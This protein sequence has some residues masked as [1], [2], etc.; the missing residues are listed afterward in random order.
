LEEPATAKDID[1]VA[2]ETGAAGE[3]VCHC[4]SCSAVGEAAA[5]AGEDDA[6]AGGCCCALRS[7]EEHHSFKGRSWVCGDDCPI[8]R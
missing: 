5:A 7:L 4:C 1:A 6:V 2:G 8:T 3:R